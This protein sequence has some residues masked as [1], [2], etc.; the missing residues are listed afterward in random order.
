MCK[1]IKKIVF[2]A[3][4]TCLLNFKDYFLCTS[5]NLKIQFII[6]LFILFKSQVQVQADLYFKLKSNHTAPQFVNLL[7]AI[8]ITKYYSNKNIIYIFNLILNAN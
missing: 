5:N 3:I 6:Y 4:L 2:L 8:Y 7:Y 1:I